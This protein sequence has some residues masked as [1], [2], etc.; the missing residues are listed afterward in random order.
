L[1]QRPSA[2]PT[3]AQETIR[4]R[5]LAWLR[6]VERATGKS[7]SRIAA[8]AG[9]SSN[10]LTRFVSADKGTLSPVTVLAVSRSTGLLTPDEMPEDI[11]GFEE[12]RRLEP[13]ALEQRSKPVAAAIALLV[14]DNPDAAPWLLNTRALEDV[15]Y[16]PG[17]VVVVDAHVKPADGDAVCAQ[18]YSRGSAETVFRLYV[19]PYYLV[20]A[21]S[22]PRLR[23]PLMVD[24]KRVAVYGTIIAS[25]RM[26][27]PR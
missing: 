7:L 21:S 27:R 19:P 5:Q 12:G 20:A 4:A 22:D 23:E 9:V 25:F 6:E 16:L 14:G 2:A 3:H 13:R 10:L 1:P 8:E 11:E 15:G 18:I 24:G 17:D 26:R